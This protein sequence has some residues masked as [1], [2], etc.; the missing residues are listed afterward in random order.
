MDPDKSSVRVSVETIYAAIY[1]QPRS[2]LKTIMIEAPQHNLRPPLPDC[3]PPRN[4]PAAEDRHLVLSRARDVAAW[5]QRKHQENT[6]G[7]LR[8]FMPK[9]TDLSNLGEAS[10]NGVAALMNT[11]PRNTI[12]Q[13]HQSK[14][15]PT[16]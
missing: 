10:L 4:D 12:G 9:G 2:G 6:K 7:L 13:K 1:A 3:R 8:Q 5:Q 16:K 14:P 11:R 15:R